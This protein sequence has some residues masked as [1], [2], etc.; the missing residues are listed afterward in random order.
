MCG[1]WALNMVNKSVKKSEFRSVKKT[2]GNHDTNFPKTRGHV[3]L[4]IIKKLYLWKAMT[5]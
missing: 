4:Y 5:I 3:K 1:S 2:M